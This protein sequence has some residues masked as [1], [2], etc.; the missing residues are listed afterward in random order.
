V[1]WGSWI[2]LAATILI[3]G[4][5]IV[6][7][8]MRRTLVSRKARKQRIADNA[9]MSGENFYTRQAIQT[10]NVTTAP[11]PPSAKPTLPV[12]SP[13]PDSTTKPSFATLDNGKEEWTPLTNDMG[14]N[15]R[16]PEDR[17][18]QRIPPGGARGGYN[19]ANNQFSQ[20][21]NPYAPGPAR[22]PYDNSLMGPPPMGGSLNSPYTPSPPPSGGM[23]GPGRGG[24]WN[25]GGPGGPY[26]GNGM[27]GRGGRGGYGP[28]PP[29]MV[30]A[31]SGGRGRGPPG[32]NARG[33][34]GGPMGPYGGGR[35]GSPPYANGYAGR[36][37]SL[38]PPAIRPPVNYDNRS[39]P[40]M[41]PAGAAAIGAGA[42]A[43]AGGFT[44]QRRASADQRGPD[45]RSGGALHPNDAHEGL[46][47]PTSVYS[48][49]ESTY[50]PVRSN[51]DHDK[52]EPPLAP[53]INERAT[54]S[55]PNLSQSL[56]NKALPARRPSE[57]YIDDVAPSFSGGPS[58]PPRPMQSG[59][60]IVPAALQPGYGARPQPNGGLN[61]LASPA[62]PANIHSASSSYSN[63]APLAINHG[64]RAPSPGRD[65]RKPSPPAALHASQSNGSLGQRTPGMIGGGAF[66]SDNGAPRRY[67]D[68][69]RRG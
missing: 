58:G 34:R 68:M 35:S 47:S 22:G 15:G 10:H 61:R 52:D 43:L 25:R 12:L 36:E 46:T 26:R 27:N 24:S 48:T 67:P 19:G 65:W 9:E 63:T 40:P 6:S 49:A 20:G 16:M 55:L 17:Y 21:S 53:F 62:P 3:A 11:P 59:N 18:G 60:A 29:G 30:G 32:Y 44:H 42:G 13:P 37:P 23:Y 56:N 14:P 38:G 69:N 50:V 41:P 64:E 39:P 57:N 8:A 5:G 54:G 2:V 7:C 1:A 31:F 45:R 33:G 51:W 66:S 28:P 4:S